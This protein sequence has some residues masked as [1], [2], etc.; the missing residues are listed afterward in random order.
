MRSAPVKS[1]LFAVMLTGLGLT[2]R[3]MRANGGTLRIYFIDVE[4]GQS[5]LV[6]T[7]TGQSLLVDAGFPSTG[8]FDSR[9]GDPA[10]ARDAQRI[11]QVARM[12]GVSRID[13]LL[14][15]HFHAD[16]AGGVPELAQ[17]IPIGTFIDH[18]GIT[19]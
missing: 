2:A 5:T 9:A 3:E 8:T 6:V 19:D 1:L 10:A 4:G 15:T 18:G 11:L 16:H 14:V 7:P 17:L 13:D 12:A